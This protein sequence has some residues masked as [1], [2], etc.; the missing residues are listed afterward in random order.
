MIR[1]NQILALIVVL[2]AG[3]GTA[4]GQATTTRVQGKVSLK[5]TMMADAQVSFVSAES[6]RAYKTK[7]DKKG[8]FQLIGL[9]VGAYDFVVSD[10]SGGCL[11]KRTTGLSMGQTGTEFNEIT[12]DINEPGEGCNAPSAPPP[13][14]RGD[15]SKKDS[16]GKQS[17]ADSYLAQA[18]DALTQ[19]NW[20]AAETALTEAIK[21]APD[22]WELYIPLAGAQENQG[23]HQEALQTDE[24]GIQRAQRAQPDPKNPYSDP[25]KIKTGIAQMLL[26]E[27][28]IYMDI[29]KPEDAAKTYLRVGDSGY[30]PATAYYNACAVYYNMGRGQD[31]VAACDKSITAD[32]NK[33]DAYFLKGSVLVNSGRLDSSGKRYVSAAAV[34][35]LK[36]Y[37]ELAP[38]G[39]HAAEAKQLLDSVVV[40]S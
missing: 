26:Q 2:L 8:E 5:G 3:A 20:P 11:Y 34:E 37:L 29:K 10:K 12:A 9:P 16:G 18:R 21:L 17:P 22:R 27:A 25:V 13:D 30:N 7:T 1:K 19:Q 40:G 24:T 38:S 4:L 33:A 6:G 23:K 36:K 31:A 15:K 35:A 32:Q 39:S 14:R 28:R